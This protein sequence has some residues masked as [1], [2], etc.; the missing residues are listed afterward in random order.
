MQ[1]VRGVDESERGKGQAREAPQSS[2]YRSP[3]SHEYSCPC[4][5]R[6]KTL[7]S[8][9]ILARCTAW[10]SVAENAAQSLKKGQRVMVIGKLVQL[11]FDSALFPRVASFGDRG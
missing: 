6:P 2:S 1:P 5:I 3:H 10:R 9:F 7:A 4:G 11:N 8:A